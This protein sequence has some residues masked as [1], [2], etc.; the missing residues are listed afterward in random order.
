M[1]HGSKGNLTVAQQLLCGGISG[2]VARTITSPLDV[3]KIIMQCQRGPV[4]TR[5][6]ASVGHA[7][8]SIMATSGIKG[9][10]RGNG[11][12]LVRMI[13]YTAIKFAAFERYKPVFADEEGKL[14]NVR[15]LVAGALAGI[16]AVAATYPL[17]V[18][19]TRFSIQSHEN[20]KYTGVLQSL[21]LIAREEGITA[22]WSGFSTTIIGVVPY[23]G[24]QFMM[25]EYIASL[26][27]EHMDRYGAH[28][29][30]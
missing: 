25:K 15:R 8:T 12:A 4:E 7:F 17:D 1:A 22:L 14:S 3:V 10:W 20:P 21:G 13:P 23:E 19:K 6:Y 2:G 29:H 11:V 5:K 28:T 9:L 16:T 26:W 18:V 24:G 30:V 27:N